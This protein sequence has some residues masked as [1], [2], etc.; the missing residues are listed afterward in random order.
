M[1]PALCCLLFLRHGSDFSEHVH[2]FIFL[3]GVPRGLERKEAHPE[4]DEPFDE[5]M[6]LLHEVVEVLPLS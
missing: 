5:A 1:P 2:R 6:I 4:L 3:Q